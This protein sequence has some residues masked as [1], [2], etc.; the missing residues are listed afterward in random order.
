MKTLTSTA[1]NQHQQCILCSTLK[2]QSLLSAF[3]LILLASTLTL[4]PPPHAVCIWDVKWVL[5]WNISM[6][7]FHLW[8]QT[9]RSLLKKSMIWDTTTV[10]FLLCHLRLE[11]QTDT[12]LDEKHNVLYYSVTLEV[13]SLI[14]LVAQGWNSGNDRLTST[15]QHP[16]NSS[17][18]TSSSRRWCLPLPSSA[19]DSARKEVNKQY[20]QNN[21]RFPSV[22]ML[23]LN[24]QS[25]R[26][27][28]AVEI[29]VRALVA[30]CEEY[31]W[32]RFLTPF[33]KG[34]GA[35]YCR[36]NGFYV[37]CFCSVIPIHHQVVIHLSDWVN[38]Q[39]F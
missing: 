31:N 13:K 19:L 10:Y 37:N 17:W 29:S 22:L 5:F 28:F 35:P 27:F 14:L 16:E 11:A 9:T 33:T 30:P 23:N 34:L 20:L 15:C 26:L 8:T 6:H 25:E 4:T 38:A 18:G 32:V 39:Y 12:G 7:F 1:N 24:R 3:Q 21:N 36:K 2:H